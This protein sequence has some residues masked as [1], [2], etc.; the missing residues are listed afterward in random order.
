MEYSGKLKSVLFGGFSKRDVLSCFE[1]MAGE[2]QQELAALTEEKQKQETE[3]EQLRQLVE[4]LNAGQ[5]TLQAQLA[6]QE[7][8]LDDAKET[9][10]RY[11]QRLHALAE[12]EQNAAR[13]VGDMMLEAKRAAS[14][15]MQRANDRAAQRGAALKQQ[16]AAA[17]QSLAALNASLGQAMTNFHDL[18]EHIIQMIEQTKNHLTQVEQNLAASALAPEQTL[19]EAA[20]PAESVQQE[21]TAAPAESVQQEKTAAPQQ[22]KGVIY[23]PF[24]YSGK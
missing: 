10:E 20:A 18:S 3:L 9:K 17:R 22:P 11:E 15:V 4:E 6:E 14:A 8:L 2:H 13:E 12:Q 16:E 1:Q 7:K 23:Y 21:K 24:P 5:E 19:S